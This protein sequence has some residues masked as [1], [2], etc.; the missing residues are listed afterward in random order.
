MDNK[1]EELLKM[2]HDLSKAVND[3]RTSREEIEKRI[4]DLIKVQSQVERKGVFDTLDAYRLDVNPK[5]FFEEGMGGV[6]D[7]IL[8]PTSNPL[9]KEI[10]RKWDDIYILSQVLKKPPQELKMWREYELLTRDIRKAMAAGTTNYGAEWIPTMFSADV[11]EQYHLALK[12]AALHTR[13]TMPSATYKYP[14][15]SQDMY[16]YLVPESTADDSTKIKSTQLKTGNITFSAKKL[17]T[18][19]VFSE[20]LSEDSIVPVLDRIKKDIAYA[21]A[22]AEEWAI[23][24][25]D[26][27]GTLDNTD[28]QG[29]AISSTSSTKAWDGYREIIKDIGKGLAKSG[30]GS[31]ASTG[32]T[33]RAIRA[34]MGK[35]GVN[36]AELAWITSVRGFVKGMMSLRDVRTLDK[37]GPDAVVLKGEMGKY[38]GIPIIVSEYVRQDLNSSGVSGGASSGYVDTQIILVHRPSFMIGDRRK[39]TMKVAEKIETDQ[40]ILVV[41]TREDFKNMRA[42]SET[43]AATLYNID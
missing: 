17:A 43:V 6:H 37:Y 23:I 14:I 31:L 41:T 42:T 21:L 39:V 5:V 3:L 26:T 2:I 16:A 30:G 22:A 34:S 36:P 25:G 18:R 12:V 32:A 9:V 38:E 35:Y 1:Y 10:Q 29:N 20:E 19:V 7:L 11:I 8:T 27:S 15:T 28:I 13:F 24:N 40:Q 4:D 33:L